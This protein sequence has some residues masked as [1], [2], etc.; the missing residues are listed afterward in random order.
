ME[1]AL[2]DLTVVS[3]AQLAQGPVAAQMLGDL[4]AEVIKVERPGGEW[5]RHWSMANQYPGGESSVFL[6]FNRNKRSIE[7]DLK[8]EEHKDVAD[9]LLDDADVVIENFRPGVMEK[10]GFGYEELSERNPELVYASASGWGRE[11]PYSDRA[12][13]DIIIQGV[14]GLASITGRRDDPPTPLGATVVDFFSSATIAFSILAALHYR[15]RTGEGQR[16]DG[17]LLN[18]ALGLQMQEISTYANAGEEPERSEAG[19][20]HVYNQAPYAVY[21]TADGYITISLSP[22]ADVGEALGLEELAA[23]DGWEEAYE[24]RDELK[25]L[26]EDLTREKTT[27]ELLDT[28]KAIREE[29]AEGV[30]LPDALDHPQVEANDM[31]DRVEHPD[32]GELEFPAL[33]V[34]FSE[35]PAETKRYPPR[36]GEHTEE[37][38]RER[39]YSDEQIERLTSHRDD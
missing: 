28:L 12:G 7:L 15:D 23:V 39:G 2:E 16:V 13:Q 10:L 29:E 8:D 25:R 35:T 38:L 22:P 11:G 31:I 20:G 1:D 32:I 5:Q 33:P 17:S 19:I 36:A 26:L 37:V 14:S 27:E 4:G 24:R 18:A 34:E 9:D 3:F 30:D 21:E 6:S